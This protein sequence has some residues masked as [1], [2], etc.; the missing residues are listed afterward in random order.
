MLTLLSRSGWRKTFNCSGILLERGNSSLCTVPALIPRKTFLGFPPFAHWGLLLH[1][2]WGGRNLGFSIHFWNLGFKFHNWGS[3]EL[4]RKKT[5]LSHYFNGF[6]ELLE[7]GLIIASSLSGDC[8][9]VFLKFRSS[10]RKRCLEHAPK[11]HR[12]FHWV[13]YVHTCYF[14]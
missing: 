1:I 13:P 6:P 11:E 10:V 4:A 8:A 5:R 2:V 3:R 9:G 7:R 14:H 12:L